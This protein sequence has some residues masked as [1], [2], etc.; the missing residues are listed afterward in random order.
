MRRHRNALRLVKIAYSADCPNERCI[1][2][3]NK[4]LVRQ[5]FLILKLLELSFCSGFSLTLFFEGPIHVI[6]VQHKPCIAELPEQLQAA[7]FRAK[8]FFGQAAV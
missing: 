3:N 1:Y 4:L 8:D 2:K 7:L 5:F 6:Y